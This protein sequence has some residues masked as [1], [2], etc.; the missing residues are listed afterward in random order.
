MPISLDG[1]FNYTALGSLSEDIDAAR[2]M[3]IIVDKFLSE[4]IDFSDYYIVIVKSVRI[5]SYNQKIFIVKLR[6]SA[7]KSYLNKTIRNSGS[8]DLNRSNIIDF[9]N[10][11]GE[12]VIELKSFGFRYNISRKLSVIGSD[13]EYIITD[14]EKDLIIDSVKGFDKIIK[15]GLMRALI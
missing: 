2:V 3:R 15:I 7:K 14:I 9:F 12:V 4:F 10:G 11:D 5:N 13:S 6:D 8:M 1:S